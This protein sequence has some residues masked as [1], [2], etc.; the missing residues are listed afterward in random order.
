M[1]LSTISVILPVYNESRVIDAVFQA[2]LPFAQQHADYQ[3]LFVDDGSDDGT[4]AQLRELT[5]EAGLDRID[6][7]RMP[8]HRGKGYAVKAAVEHCTGQYICFADGDLAYSLDHL[9]Q[10]VAA[11]AHDDVVIGSRALAKLGQVN[12]P[13]WRK[14]MGKAFNVC[15]RLVL[16]L[17]YRDTQAG[18]KGFRAEAARAIFS[19]QRTFDFTFDVELI[20]LA[21]KLGYTIGEIPARV[22][23]DHSRKSSNVKPLRDPVR[24]LPS[25]CRIRINSLRGFYD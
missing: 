25:L 12:V 4:D 19:R 23:E 10:L 21:R 1:R 7:L 22:S 8:E 17:P 24:M 15:A 18:L 9:H 16:Y 20:Y 2:V 3:F 14:C 5:R 6:V 13:F 11:L